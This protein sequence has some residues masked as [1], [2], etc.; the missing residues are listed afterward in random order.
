MGLHLACST[1]AVATGV[2]RSPD[3]VVEIVSRSSAE[4]D[5]AMAHVGVSRCWV[6]EYWVIDARDTGDVQFD[7][8]K[9][10]GKE[11]T[12]GRKQDGWV[13]SSVSAGCFGLVRKERKNG[14]RVSRSKFADE[15]VRSPR[16]PLRQPI[17]LHLQTHFAFWVG[18][19]ATNYAQTIMALCHISDHA[20]PSV[21]INNSGYIVARARTGRT[22]RSPALHRT[23][24][25]RPINGINFRL[26]A[27]SKSIS[28]RGW[29]APRP[30]AAGCIP[31]SSPSKAKS[32]YR[33]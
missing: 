33:R 28:P 10:G 5:N 7:I 23:F 14:Y 3:L 18:Q 31:V 4:I 13:K 12:A 20:S 26:Q 32:A 1:G 27:R 30:F 17:P 15:S 11:Y 25:R 24:P 22:T 29:F 2:V 9:R 8:Y 21:R 16:P 19:S 6:T